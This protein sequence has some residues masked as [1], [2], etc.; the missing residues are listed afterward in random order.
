MAENNNMKDSINSEWMFFASLGG[1]F[2]SN[3]RA[4]DDP[5]GIKA[6]ESLTPGLS[7]GEGDWYDLSGRKINSQ[8]IIHNSQLPKGIYIVNGRKVLVK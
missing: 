4:E 6:V 5:V 8:F 1:G 3:L 7:E 2:L